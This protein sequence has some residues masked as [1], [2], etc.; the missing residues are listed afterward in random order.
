ML[1]FIM[2]LPRSA[3]LLIELHALCRIDEDAIQE[4][5]RC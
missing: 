5:M 4:V 2:P 3:N 1:R